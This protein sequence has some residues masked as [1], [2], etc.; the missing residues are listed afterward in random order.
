MLVLFCVPSGS[1]V[2]FGGVIF[3][4]GFDIC[5]ESVVW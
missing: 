1:L 4:G 3:G 5:G 2:R